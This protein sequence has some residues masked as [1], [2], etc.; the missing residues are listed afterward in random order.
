MVSAPGLAA[1]LATVVEEWDAEIALDRLSAAALAITKSRNSMI[2]RLDDE[3]ATVELQHGVGHDWSQ[4]RAGEQYKVQVKDQGGIVAY[5]AAT[6]KSVVSGNVKADPRYIPMFHTTQS[7][8]AVPVR[9]ADGRIRGV[10]NIESDKPDYYQEGDLRLCEFLAGLGALLL[11]R[12]E[13]HR[14]EAA[15]MQIAAELGTALTEEDLVQG[16]LE[17][18][19]NVL[20]TSACSIFLLAEDGRFML[21]GSVGELQ[22]Q[23]N[24][25]GYLPGQG[26][27]G[28]VAKNGEE[29]LVSHPKDD[30][31]WRGLYLEMAADEIESYMAAPIRARGKTIG[32]IRALRHVS[33]N[34]YLH[35][36]FS[37]SDVRLLKA[38]A[39]Q[40]ATGLKN[41][42][43]MASALHTERMAAW[44]E[45]SA[46]SSHMIGNRVFAIR[47]DVNELGYL[48]EQP[49]F[50]K[51]Q[52][53]GVHDSLSTSVT[54]IEE[55]L[56]DFRDFVTAVKIERTTHALNELVRE[57]VTEVF[58]KG[59]PV[60]LEFELA[61]GLPEVSVDIRRMRRAIGEIVENSL[62]HV[63]VGTIT[64][65]T[66]VAGPEN[67]RAAGLPEASQMVQIEIEDQGP[68]IPADK[69]QTIFQP[70]F[71]SRVKG[72]GLGLSIVKGVLDAHGGT[73]METGEEG[74]GA[75]F[76]MLLPAAKRP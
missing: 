40:V 72:M 46:R 19:G 6:G 24:K 64:V 49:D 26:L 27:T 29:L 71:T 60:G 15:L 22:S 67:L 50:D 55:I 28:W 65:R 34:P 12:E 56:Q 63:Q 41:I 7:E 48:L 38:V 52:L 47:G 39:D 30:P 3:R 57:A 25:I 62:H 2:A 51:D 42:R 75:R 45:M 1:L 23:T 68:G 33:D 20:R 32:V 69:K 17:V 35:N 73:V 70:Y 54:R 18:A 10:L 76:V 53:S 5:V 43:A 36:T 16:V 4:E 8:I 37:A 44:G 14:H 66:G 61:D 13:A 9:D 58:P 31:R 21:R 11:D 59:A 74:K